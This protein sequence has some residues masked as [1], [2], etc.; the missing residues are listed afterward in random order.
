ML[1][2]ELWSCIIILKHSKSCCY[3][4]LYIVSILGYGNK[5][6]AI[7][8]FSKECVYKSTKETM[9]VSM[10]STTFS[11]NTEE[12]TSFVQVSIVLA[13]IFLLIPIIID[14]LNYFV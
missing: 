5:H 1:I 12:V 3:T 6:P 2:V 10:I 8:C 4:Y 7:I 11:T 14:I 13:C 9:T